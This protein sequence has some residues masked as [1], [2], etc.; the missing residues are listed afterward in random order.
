[1][2]DMRRWTG[3]V[4]APFAGLAGLAAQDP[5][6]AELKF[7]SQKKWSIAL[8]QETWTNVQAGLAV[9]PDGAS[10]AAH[11]KGLG[12]ALDV[13]T[14][15]D[16][17]LDKAVKGQKGFLL[18]RDQTADGAKFRYAAR[19][20]A[21]GTTYQFASAGFMV[22]RVAG[23]SIRLIDQNNNGRYDEFG[24]DAMIV[25]KG[26]SASFLSKVVNLDG[27]LYEI[28]VEP[29]GS[30]VEIRPF[31][32]ESGTLNLARGYRSKGKLLSAVVEDDHGNS[33]QLASTSKG[34]LVPAGDYR[35]AYGRI[36]KGGEVAKI[37]HGNMD[38]FVVHGGRTT[39]VAWGG[40]VVAVFDHLLLLDKVTID[41]S[42][43]QYYGETGE[44][45]LEFEPKLPVPKFLVYDE[46]TRKLLK[47]GRFGT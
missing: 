10:F 42:V 6:V 11:R 40:K 1:M 8:P 39:D 34:L 22:G 15:G 3:L 30:K 5:V 17:K 43:M 13:D 35:L 20:R 36:Q 25:G 24:V 47:T 33:F 12:L 19:F 37:A 14:D 27:T 23:E 45:Y 7:K 9:G 28:E 18:L 16:G 2:R 31:Q 26:S 41:P 32:G 44:Q 38:D 4:L 21:S 29:D 46:R